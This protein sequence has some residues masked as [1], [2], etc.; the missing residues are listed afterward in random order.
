MFHINCC[1]L[2]KISLITLLLFHFCGLET[3]V[4]SK[5]YPS[6]HKE[7][8]EMMTDLR[9]LMNDVKYLKKKCD[10]SDSVENKIK[11]QKELKLSIDK[12]DKIQYVVRNR[13][14]KCQHDHKIK[15]K[16]ATEM[17]NAVDSIDSSM[18]DYQ[19]YYKVETNTPPLINY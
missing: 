19:S 5:L 10:K 2:I 15:T 8:E 18:Q 14:I 13:L 16:V 3:F 17:M 1:F 7:L 12:I 4:L 9:Y 6:C 11:I